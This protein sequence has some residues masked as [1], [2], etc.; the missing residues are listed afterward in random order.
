MT[1]I[2]F[3]DDLSHLVQVVTHPAC[4]FRAECWCGWASAWSDA[5]PPAHA[6][7]R[8]HRAR[9]VAPHATRAVILAA[10]LD[11][12]DDLADTIQLLAGTTPG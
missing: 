11:L 5:R 8:D 7:S 10:L 1:S 6:A 9:T 3:P 4:G 12:Q 2:P